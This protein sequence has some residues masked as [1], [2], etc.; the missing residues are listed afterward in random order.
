MK[1]ITLSEYDDARDS[2]LGWCPTCEE[3][4][5]DS[6]EPDADGY[7]CPDCGG[8]RVVG[9]EQALLLGLVEIGDPA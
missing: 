1:T 3:F 7:D 8:Q 2:H 6:T 4:A 9:A 5:R